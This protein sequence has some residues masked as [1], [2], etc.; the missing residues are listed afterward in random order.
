MENENH[1]AIVT[2]L[3]AL[4]SDAAIEA[5]NRDYLKRIAEAPDWP[6]TSQ[7][8]N[9]RD[10]WWKQ[11]RRWDEAEKAWVPAEQRAI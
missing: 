10:A 1:A 8:M 4:L 6:M 5:K 9:E 3:A 7:L 2:E 11:H